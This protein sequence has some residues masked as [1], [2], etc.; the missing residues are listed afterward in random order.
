MPYLKKVTKYIQH[1]K[2]ISCSEVYKPI[3]Q[4]VCQALELTE[5]K[6]QDPFSIDLTQKQMLYRYVGTI[7][8]SY[9]C[10]WFFTSTKEWIC[11]VHTVQVF[12]FIKNTDIQL[13]LIL[14]MGTTKLLSFS[15]KNQFLK[16]IWISRLCRPNNI[17][18]CDYFT[19][20]MMIRKK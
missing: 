7:I 10:S 20:P 16:D 1:N 2:C 6:F 17:E 12:S 5:S 19:V 18:F 3:S 14:W 8:L 15:F 13:T 4:Y 9:I 11:I